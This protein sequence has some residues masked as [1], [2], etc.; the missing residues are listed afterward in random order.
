MSDQNIIEI[1]INKVIHKFIILKLIGEGAQSKVYKCTKKGVKETYALK[2]YSKQYLKNNPSEKELFVNEY[3]IHKSLD[4]KNILKLYNIGSDLHNY[5][6]I[7]EFCE[8]GTLDKKKLLPKQIKKYSYELLE[9]LSYLKSMKVLHLDLK[10]Q[11]ILIHKGVI[12]IADFGL[13]CICDSDSISIHPRGT[14]NYISP[15][16]LKGENI[17]FS[18]DLWSAGIIIYFMYYHF[19][20]FKFKFDAKSNM[21]EELTSKDRENEFDVIANNIISKNVYMPN[22]SQ[23]HIKD[24]IKKIL[25]KN[26]SERMTIDEA[27][28]HRYYKDE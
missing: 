15:E 10:P 20:P 16:L 8:S 25:V 2:V 24:L 26:P 14:L 13:S 9:A 6:L 5:Y 12:K 11:N 21:P 1:H 22:H 17:N 7:F 3:N 23:N 4:H 28:N 18:T 19:L 27:L